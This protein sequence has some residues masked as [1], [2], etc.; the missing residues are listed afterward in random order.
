MDQIKLFIELTRFKKPIGYMLLFWPC[1]WGLSIAYDFNGEVTTYIFYILLFLT[2]SVLMR[3]AGC[4]VN[5]IFDKNFDKKVFR[6]KNRPIASKKISV[7]KGIFYSLSLCFLAF[8][9]LIQFNNFTILLA[10]GS[11]P[12]AF[13]YPLMK[14]YTYWPQLFLGVTFN[15]GLILGWTSV[16]GELNL[17][18]LIFYVGAIFWTLGYDTIYGFQDIEDDEII[19]LKSTSIKF[20]QIPG[21]FLTISYLIFFICLIIVGTLL[22]LNLVFYFI[23][24]VIG[25]QLFFL[26]IKKLDI[27]SSKNCLSIFK[28]NNIIGFLVFLSLVLG[29]I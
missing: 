29:K 10:F 22:M 25:F 13:T 14:R 9:V 1:A 6:T 4:I 21:L 20:K 24:I 3:S 15:Y 12:L 17:I 28:S 7:K 2:G 5:D 23:S 26:Q 8:I 27:K 19:G 18:P 11:M 16:T